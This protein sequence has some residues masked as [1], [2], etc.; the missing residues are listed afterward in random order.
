MVPLDWIAKRIAEAQT[1]TP[2]E[3]AVVS[4]LEEELSVT[5]RERTL[6]RAE[7]ADLA[8]QLIAATEPPEPAHED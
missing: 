8:K 3:A 6:T 2:V 5:M 4:C 7:L 1:A